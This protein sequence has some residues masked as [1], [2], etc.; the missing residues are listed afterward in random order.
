MTPP[1]RAEGV[2]TRMLSYM[3]G[4][5]ASMLLPF[6]TLPIMTRWLV[7]EDYGIVALAQI[8]A[9][10][11]VGLSTC[12]IRL[13]VERNYFQHDGD[14]RGLGRLMFSALA[15]VAAG[16][17]VCGV[18][19][20][21]LRH[22]LSTLLYGTPAWGGLIV[23]VALTSVVGILVTLQLVYLR[24][25]GRA[26]AF[27]RYS[28]VGL[29]LE[30]GLAV[31]LVVNGAG[32]WGLVLAPLIGK[33]LVAAVL[34]WHCARECGVG[35]DRREAREMLAIGTPLMP[36]TWMATA[37][38][39]VDRLL[40]SWLASLGQAGLFAMAHRVGG[41]V[42]AVMTSLEQVYVPQVY[43]LFFRGGPDT[44]RDVGRYLSPF[45]YASAV[46]S[47]VAIL[48]I[49]EVL[50][51]LVTPAF[52][53]AQ[54]MAAILAAY[55]GQMFFGKLVGV[56]F[57]YLKKTWY[58]TPFA[59][60]RLLVHGALAVWWIPSGGAIGAA[61]AL[62]IAGIVVEGTA[63]LV[64]QRACPIRYEMAV[65]LPVLAL[66][67]GAMAWVLVTGSLGWPYGPRLAGKLTI[68]ALTLCLGLRWA[69]LAR[70]RILAFMGRPRLAVGA[71]G[72]GRP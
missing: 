59:L 64:A 65:V 50:W 3:G 47:V 1:D 49:E 52:Y 28:L 57:T 17:A 48:F 72:G 70:D 35:F 23:V 38:N 12:E 68:V 58:A 11:F 45:F 44:A 21:A 8:V 18:L 20:V 39:G 29:L 55:Y 25:R 33:A 51:L 16:T 69:D 19:L 31:G 71:T 24:N 37:D 41:S 32:V 40:I 15:I 66:M 61:F 63:A 62:L 46:V 60:F 36:R 53:G 54:F 14:P 56:Q 43:R 30:S 26:R 2:V 10:V 27:M 67:Y 6:L 9:A 42:F 13:G 7:P 4:T 22:W 34:W 5:A